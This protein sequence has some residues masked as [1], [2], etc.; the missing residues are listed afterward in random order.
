MELSR[1]PTLT[2]STVAAL[3]QARDS[4]ALVTRQYLQSIVDRV[5]ELDV[6][7]RLSSAGELRVAA[8]VANTAHTLGLETA[9]RAYRWSRRAVLADTADRA[10]WRVMAQA[11]DQLQV[12]QQKPQWFATILTCPATAGGRCLLAPIDTTRVTDP[13]RVELGLPTLAQ[14]REHLDSLNRARTR[15]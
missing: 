10:S 11:W 2:D 14:R 8:Q 5:A 9:E 6:C 1:L 3:Q 4:Q 15:P 7:R 13:Q 12:M